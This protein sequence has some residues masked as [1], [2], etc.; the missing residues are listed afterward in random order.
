MQFRIRLLPR[1]R[2]IELGLE[3]QS[4]GALELPSDLFG[5]AIA[6]QPDRVESK[7]LDRVADRLDERRDV[8]RN[9]R[10]STD[11][12]ELADLHELMHR[13]DAGNDRLVLDGHV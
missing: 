10:A 13:G 11:E 5:E 12:A 2:E 7:Q 1:L 6:L 4:V 9:A 3:E 8:L